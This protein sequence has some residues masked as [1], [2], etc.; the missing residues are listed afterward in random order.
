MKTEEFKLKLVNATKKLCREFAKDCEEKSKYYS[1]CQTPMRELKD[2]YEGQQR[3]FL[4]V[5]DFLE[6]DLED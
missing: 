5:A 4:L 6:K 1:K 3:A 2:Y